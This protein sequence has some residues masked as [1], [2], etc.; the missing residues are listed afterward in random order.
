MRPS[1]PPEQAMRMLL[2]LPVST[3]TVQVPLTEAR[4]RILAEDRWATL[5]SPPFDRS[6]YDGF[7]LRAGDLATAT[8]DEPTTLRVTECITAGQVPAR[9]LSAGTAAKIMTGAP[10]PA[11][12]DCV[13]RK[14]DARE[15]ARSSK[16]GGSLEVSFTAPATPGTN[17]I[18]AGE[19][20]PAGT[21]LM[22]RG[23]RIGLG[24]I[25]MLA[26]Q[27][28]ASCLTY[29]R[30][31][32]TVIPTGDELLRPGEPS[33]LHIRCFYDHDN[34]NRFRCMSCCRCGACIV[35]LGERHAPTM[36]PRGPDGSSRQARAACVGRV[37]TVP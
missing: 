2:D 14:E 21:M 32:A 19:E 27:G 18:R 23:T 11:G 28:R 36:A 34:G 26:S 5:P 15:H 4:G 33:E 31:K 35:I 3:R 1:I 30:P 24:E 8:A 25:G 9:A 6:P 17:V 16:R 20:Y 10:L 7:A 29:R 37:C 22:A 12:A 13:I